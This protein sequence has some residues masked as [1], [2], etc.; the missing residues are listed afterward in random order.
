MLLVGFISQPSAFRW[1]ITIPIPVVISLLFA[2]FR[3]YKNNYF[4]I[5]DCLAFALVALSTFLIMYTY[6]THV[7]YYI[8]LL[9]VILL[10]PFL[11]FISFILYKIFSQVALLRA[12]CSRIK[13][14]LL[15][16]NENQYQHVQRGDNEDLPD[17]IVNPDI[18][19]PL[20][21][22]TNNSSGGEGDSQSDHQPQAGVNS[23][24]PYGSM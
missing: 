4:N 22:A 21:P 12:C 14:I 9:Y 20:L 8:Q 5:I 24:A 1:L 7:H 2:L 6:T 19:Q 11:Y 16:R 10:T 23:L 17:R 18:Y 15:S 3:P 13:K